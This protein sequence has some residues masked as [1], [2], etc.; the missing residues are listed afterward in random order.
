MDPDEDPALSGNGLVA[1]GRLQKYFGS[2]K[3]W[4]IR[5]EPTGL[6]LRTKFLGFSCVGAALFCVLNQ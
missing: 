6:P 3:G 4:P 2:S 1:D 5:A